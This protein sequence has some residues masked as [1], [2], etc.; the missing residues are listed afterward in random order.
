MN[1]VGG[2]K[3]H[4]TCQS[5]KSTLLSFHSKA[6]VSEKL[7]YQGEIKKLAN[8]SR[9]LHDGVRELFSEPLVRK[10]YRLHR[11]G[12]VPL[13]VCIWAQYP[14]SEMVSGYDE[15]LRT[16]RRCPFPISAQ[17]D[18]VFSDCMR[19]ERKNHT[20]HRIS[21]PHV[22]WWNNSRICSVWLSLLLSQA[23]AWDY[24]V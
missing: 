1:D 11:T 20:R 10:T 8:C 22:I 3:K 16:G 18:M 14:W 12:G 4:R 24:R 6:H 17:Q 13:I 7:W 23:S 15:E 9:Q 5:A 19:K 2:A 21:C